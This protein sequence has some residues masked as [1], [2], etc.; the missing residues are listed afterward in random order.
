MFMLITDSGN[1]VIVL[2]KIWVRFPSFSGFYTVCSNKCYTTSSHVSL[3]LDAT[4]HIESRPNILGGFKY[5]CDHSW[6][7][8]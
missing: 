6:V 1:T 3:T 4:V 5:D 8:R 7:V 2:F